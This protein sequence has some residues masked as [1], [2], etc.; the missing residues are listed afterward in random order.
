MMSI[1]RY[2]VFFYDEF[3]DEER[4]EKGICAGEN[5]GDAANKLVDSSTGY[6]DV[7]SIKLRNLD[8]EIITDKDLEIELRI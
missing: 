2:E 6:G 1:F 4:T 5:Y 8:D 7:I 3:K